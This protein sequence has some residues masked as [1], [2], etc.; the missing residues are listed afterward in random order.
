MPEKTFTETEIQNHAFAAVIEQGKHCYRGGSVH[1]LRITGNDIIAKVGNE[2]PQSVAITRKNGHPLRFACTCGFSF[3]GAC[4]HVVAVMFACNEQDAQQGVL[5]FASVPPIAVAGTICNRT[6]AGTGDTP[7]DAPDATETG[8]VEKREKPVG[9]LYLSESDNA[10]FIEIRFAYGEAGTEFSRNDNEPSRLVPGMDGTVCRIIRSRIR[11]AQLTEQLEHRGLRPYRRGV[12]TP[13]IDPRSWIEQHLEMLES[14]GFVIFGPDLLRKGNVRQTPPRLGVGV[15]ARGGMIECTVSVQCEGISATLAAL[16]EAVKSKSKYILLSDGTSCTLP[17]QWI[18]K[19][20]ALFDLGQLSPDTSSVRL[21]QNQFPSALLM[22][23]I[24]DDFQCDN[25]SLEARKS[26]KTFDRIDTAALPAN[27]A[28][29]LRPYQHAGYSWLHFLR[30]HGFGGVLADDMG[31]GK[32]VQTLTMLQYEK[33]AARSSKPSLI[34]APASLLFNWDREA[35]KFTPELLRL[36]YHGADRRRYT[37]DILAKADIIITTYATLLRDTEVL[38]RIKFR[39]IILDE[40]QAIKNPLSRAGKALRTLDTDHKLC[41]SGTPI[42]NSLAELWSLFSFLNPGMLGRYSSFVSK[43]ARPIER[44]GRTS[45]AELL[46]SIVYPFIL[47]RTKGQ[48]AHDLPPLSEQV[49]IAEMLPR[50]KALYEITRDTFRG[51]LE[52]LIHDQGVESAGF[53]VLE[54]LL[55]LRQICCHPALYDPSFGGESAKFRLT[56]DLVAELIAGGHK[57]LIFSQFV[58]ALMLLQV[59]FGEKRIGCELLTGSTRDRAGVV[60]HFQQNDDVRVFLISL[61]AGG[62][63]LNLTAADYV[64]HLDPW[65]NPAIEA[66]AS[67]RAHRIGQNRH[68]FAYKLIMKDTIEER[69]LELQES[70][71]QLAELI[72]R[73]D[74]SVFKS[75]ESADILKLFEAQ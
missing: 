10:L 42:E 68:V 25:W 71:K 74:H 8:I 66:Q 39:W 29:T 44:E 19:F 34:V 20:T 53:A 12:F 26:L 47:R 72:I 54:G 13:E 9:R 63:G 23:D 18:D 56:E 46:R 30:K 40:A 22:Q 32:T 27:L 7:G 14:E 38:S 73:T 75:L 69:V 37:P 61:K 5:D 55:R 59:R 1:S 2:R 11:E 45:H 70:K 67:S 51:K 58:Q 48:V 60:D 64:I 15:S 41:L 43:F 24:A 57:V 65:W 35:R 4:E 36:S 31:L 21:W 52:R 16:I 3:G 33:E 6:D 17:P 50:Q 62:T 28:C 49:T